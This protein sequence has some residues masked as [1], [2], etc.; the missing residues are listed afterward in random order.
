MP[1]AKILDA[2]YASRYMTPGWFTFTG[3]AHR[4]H[5]PVGKGYTKSICGAVLC[6]ETWLVKSR[7]VQGFTCQRC[8]QLQRRYREE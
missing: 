5:L 3:K 2:Y 7:Y 6:P 4:F 8:M 1:N